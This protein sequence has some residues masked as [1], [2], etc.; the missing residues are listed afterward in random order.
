VNDQTLEGACEAQVN[1]L[2]QRVASA[3][4]RRCMEL[5]AAAESQA[6]EIVHSARVEARANVRGA[7]ARERARMEKEIRRAEA[8]AELESAQR[9]QREIQTLLGHMWAEIETVLER[10]W[11]DPVRRRKWIEA[12]IAQAGVLLGA[13]PWRVE[14]SD[15]WPE[16]ERREIAH[17]ARSKGARAIEWAC[18]PQIHAG[19]RVRTNGVC[20]AAT[21]PALLA[22]RDDIESAFLAEYLAFEP[23]RDGAPASASDNRQHSSSR[24][25]SGAAEQPGR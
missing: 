24:G 5:R 23:T 11:R 17:L 18:D 14:Y 19:L 2:L 12:A 21:V 22:R 16:E 10:R 9:V 20:L 3:T 1:A 25:D 4:E 13:R 8:R 15:E 6:R 7:V